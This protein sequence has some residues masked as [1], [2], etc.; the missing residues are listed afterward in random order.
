MTLI[1]EDLTKAFTYRLPVAA[2][3]GVLTID[4]QLVVD[5]SRHQPGWQVIGERLG[6]L[7][8][9]WPFSH[10]REQM[11]RGAKKFVADLAKRGYA[12]STAEAD[13]RIWGPYHSRAWQRQ[14]NGDLRARGRT[15]G[16]V[17]FDDAVD[18][19]IVGDFVASRLHLVE[20]SVRPPWAAAMDA[21]M[22]AQ[23][24]DQK[25]H[26]PPEPAVHTALAKRA[27]AKH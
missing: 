7:D 17:L 20:P 14:R 24:L 2:L 13:L 11:L 27:A 19:L 5:L 21:Q 23:S 25:L 1:R 9:L 18:F 26:T 8:S 3:R 12:L 22:D 10:F 16:E 4:M 15:A 6:D